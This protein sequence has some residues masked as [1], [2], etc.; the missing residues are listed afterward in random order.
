MCR[1]LCTPTCR[2]SLP[3]PPRCG[4]LN[5]PVVEAK[6]FELW[7]GAGPLARS[8]KGVE[9]TS[10]P[11]RRRSLREGDAIECDARHSSDDRVV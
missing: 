8:A 3:A 7:G 9:L 10:S 1:G 5:A 2:P 6:P 11:S 4:L